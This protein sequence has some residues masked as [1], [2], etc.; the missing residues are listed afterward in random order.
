MVILSMLR[1][2]AVTGKRPKA[3]TLIELLVVIAI[4]AILA[5][6]LFPV[7]A[8]AREKARQASCLSNTKQLALAVLQYEQDADETLPMGGWRNGTTYG[9][10]YK[11]M[12]PYFK[13]TAVLVCPSQTADKAVS[14]N[15]ASA[16]IPTLVDANATFPTTGPSSG[17]GYAMNQNI[18]VYP[19]NPNALATFVSPAAITL[20][21]IP[22][23]AGTFIFCDGAQLLPAFNIDY[24]TDASKWNKYED[25]SVDWGLYPPSTF[26]GGAIYTT[27]L[28]GNTARR[29]SPRHN[30]GLCVVYCDGHAKWQNI[31][32][33][34]GVTP[35][36][37]NGWPYGDPK[38]QWDNK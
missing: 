33:W 4:I 18:G 38:N 34:L 5:A 27:A 2:N 8:Q 17:G 1:K 7:F 12:Y 30:G 37:P 32:S 21:D 11:D 14:G 26:T 36:Q 31:S 10:W 24:P 20:N 13:S 6:I 16:F 25:Y 19:Y 28:N 3:F 9:K 29:P 35:A 22:D 23:S 15:G